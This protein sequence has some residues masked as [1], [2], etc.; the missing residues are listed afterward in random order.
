MAEPPSTDLSPALLSLVRACC[1]EVRISE[2]ARR[3]ACVLGTHTSCCAAGLAVFD[4]ERGEVRRFT[5]QLDTRRT[6]SFSLDDVDIVELSV[7]AGE[8]EA[9]GLSEGLEEFSLSKAGD[10]AH[11]GVESYPLFGGSFFVS[12]PIRMKDQL[13]GMVYASSNED[14]CLCLTGPLRDVG[15]VITPILYN[16]LIHERF[17]RGDQRR[18]CLL[19]LAGVISSSLDLKRVLGAALRVVGGL[20]GHRASAICLLNNG[21][22]TFRT[23]S[24]SRAQR[25]IPELEPT[26]HRLDDTP[27]GWL[28]EHGK[29]YESPELTTDVPFAWDSDLHKQGVRRYLAVPLVARGRILGAFLFGRD[30]PRPWRKVEHWMYENIALQLALAIDNITKHEELRQWSGQ[31]ESQNA[32]L[33]EEIDVERGFRELIGTSPAMES[34]RKDVQ[35]VAPTDA[36]VLITGETGAGKEMIAR[37]IHQLSDRA[38]LPLIKVNC[39]SIPET[40]FESEL[41]GHER[42]AFTSAVEKRIGRFEL[43]ENGTIFLDEIGELSLAVQSKLLRVLQDGEFERVGGSKTLKSNARVIA[44]TNRELSRAI[45][46]GR[47]RSDLYYRL[48]VF[49]IHVPP[50]RERRGDIPSLVT[51]FAEEFSR[52]SGKPFMRVDDSCLRD[53]QQL[54]WPGNVR[55]LRHVVERAVILSDNPVLTI[56]YGASDADTPDGQAGIQSRLDE[57]QAA[58]I[59]RV[60]ND[61]RWVVEG[62]RGAACALGIK[63]STLRFRMNRLGIERPQDGS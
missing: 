12:V 44:A 18:D 25:P 30:D 38:T 4:E 57:V 61:C 40:M 1:E 15:Q 21:N 13:L 48:N 52:K 19:E 8:T 5:A 9:A 46:E 45:E 2:L 17:A 6:S 3:V 42:G 60:L 26:I 27:I 33:R 58:E 59:R 47:F 22:R 54:N 10:Q 11:S 39:P 55:E 53:L 43:A 31:L 16:C 23:F 41:F 37:M 28:L 14:E 56:E 29:T 51:A 49:P 36:S 63:P 35:R 24:Q 20:E 32:Y 7:D 50:L 62:P 34:L